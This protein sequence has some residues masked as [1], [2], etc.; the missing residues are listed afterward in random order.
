MQET[1]RFYLGPERPMT[2]WL[3]SWDEVVQAADGGLLV[4][5]QWVELKKDLGPS[6]AKVNL[7]LAKDLA[8]LSADGGL[9]IFGITDEFKVIGCDHAAVT[10]RISQ[11]AASRI[12]P[13]LSPLIH[14]PIASPDDPD[15]AVVIV[16]VPP[17]AVAPHMVD[18]HYW[19]RSSDGKR[20]LSDPEIRRLM[21]IRASS[22]ADFADRLMRL[23]AAD[24][25]ARHVENH[26]TGQGHLY[27]LAEPCSTVPANSGSELDL[28]ST[29]RG[30]PHA[31]SRWPEHLGE[32]RSNA[33]DPNGTALM[34]RRETMSAQDEHN[35]AYVSVKDDHR[36]VVVDGGATARTMNRAEITSILHSRIALIVL[37]A[38]E[39]LRALSLDQWGYVGEWRVGIHVTELEGLSANTNQMAVSRPVPFAEPTYTRTTT[40]APATWPD[41]GMSAAHSLL[42][43][44]FRGL[45]LENWDYDTIL[46]R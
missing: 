18:G 12:T 43:G 6:N 26:P 7:E 13:P 44:M 16:E 17:S 33:F 11:V 28:R 22:D 37:Q 34:T 29:L 2:T 9:L 15:T 20:V 21:E 45:G 8:A 30:I 23:V 25:L 42:R 27:L 1:R 5:R 39:L 19:G 10:T 38:L 24:P 40:T 36:L 46:S 35:L 4:E 3:R 41:A 31:D 14:D 32:C